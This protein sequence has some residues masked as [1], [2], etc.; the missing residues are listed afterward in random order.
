MEKCIKSP[1]VKY[2]SIIGQI[3]DKS[4]RSDGVVAYRSSHLDGVESEL[5]VESSHTE[6]T[7]CPAAI[8]EVGRIL[9]E[10]METYR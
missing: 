7:H 2:H 10:N 1:Y 9:I 3:S 8:I 6:I 5:I 4:Q